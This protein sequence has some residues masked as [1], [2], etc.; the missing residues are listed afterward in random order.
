MKR[1]LIVIIV[2]LLLMVGYLLHQLNEKKLQYEMSH[3][4]L[5]Q[6]V[7]ELEEDKMSLNNTL[8]DFHTQ[9]FEQASDIQSLKNMLQSAFKEYDHVTT[10][11][12]VM[13]MIDIESYIESGDQRYELPRQGEFFIT[14]DHFTF[15]ASIRIP[16]LYDDELRQ[17]F[18][19]VGLNPLFRTIYYPKASE[20]IEKDRE[21]T[22]TYKNLDIG[23]RIQFKT[24]G[25]FRSAFNIESETITIIRVDETKYQSGSDYFPSMPISITEYIDE[26]NQITHDY[27]EI[28]EHEIS[29]KT[30]YNG[31]EYVDYYGGKI[32][33]RNGALGYIES[34]GP[35]TI[36]DTTPLNVVILPSMMIKGIEV[37]QSKE[38][39]S[40]VHEK[41]NLSIDGVNYDCIEIKNYKRE[42]Y[43][44]SSYYAMGIGLIK[45]TQ[46]DQLSNPEINLV[47][48]R[49]EFFIKDE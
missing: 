35:N 39:Y 24:T 16:P 19:G 6:V 37:H 22:L 40:V 41:V 34:V 18:E 42:R 8:Q 30:F 49:I 7:Y 1:N 5:T 48:K 9:T 12:L 26:E 28:G 29:Y 32:Y 38:Y 21:L 43:I 36:N 20:R 23:D 10:N 44:G 2:A 14:E 15:H 13:D 47:D 27:Y 17:S 25:S 31:H 3:H 45:S 11:H 4:N 33:I 46:L